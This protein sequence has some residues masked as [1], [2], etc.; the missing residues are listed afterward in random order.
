[1]LILI[2][3]EMAFGDKPVRRKLGSVSDFQLLSCHKIS[4]FHIQQEKKINFGK[5]MSFVR[6]RE[7]GNI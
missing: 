5:K 1:M 3:Q 6:S 4:N 7:M 2:R